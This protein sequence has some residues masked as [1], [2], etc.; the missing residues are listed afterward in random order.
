MQFYYGKKDAIVHVSV[1]QDFLKI[2]VDLG[3]ISPD[4]EV[5]AQFK[6]RDFKNNGTF[7]SDSNGLEMQK[8]ILNLR[9]DWNLQD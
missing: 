9:P 2:D 1:D 4:T 3:S 6:L 7:Y 8:R 5:V